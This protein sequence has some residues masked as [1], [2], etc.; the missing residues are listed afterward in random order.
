MAVFCIPG[1]VCAERYRELFESNSDVYNDIGTHNLLHSVAGSLRGRPDLW[2]HDAAGAGTDAWN[3]SS[4]PAGAG[5]SPQSGNPTD[6]QVLAGRKDANGKPNPAPWPWFKAE[7]K[8]GSKQINVSIFVNFDTRMLSGDEAFHLKTLAKDGVA[9]FW[10]R[11]VNLNGDSYGVTVRL[12]EAST[13]MPIMLLVNEKQVPVASVNALG[14][15][16]AGAAVIGWFVGA[17]IY[18]QEEYFK[19]IA[20]N[21]PPQSQYRNYTLAA[22]LNFKR[23]A[24]HEIGHPILTIAK[25]VDYSWGHEGTSTKGGGF[26]NNTPYFPQTGEVSLMKYFQGDDVFKADLRVKASEDDVKSLIYISP[27]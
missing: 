3:N 23:T 20:P 10:S 18:Y 9:Q 15:D 7:I 22:D 5:V 21:Y 8:S 27:R 17:K 25:G 19:Y 4:P 13:G 6:S 24:A 14:A 26:T 1:H 2:F 12:Y 11:S 16:S